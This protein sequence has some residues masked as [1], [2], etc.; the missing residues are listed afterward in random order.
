MNAFCS[1]ND[2]VF[3][4]ELDKLGNIFLNC[5]NEMTRKSV[6]WGELGMNCC[7][8]HSLRCH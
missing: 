4:D 8:K 3:P 2:N 7:L 5:T 1:T 6:L